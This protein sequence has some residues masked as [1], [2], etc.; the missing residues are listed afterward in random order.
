V[1][2]FQKNSITAVVII[3]AAVLLIKIFLPNMWDII[4]FKPPRIVSSQVT[5]LTADLQNARRQNRDWEDRYNNIVSSSTTDITRLN[6]QLEAQLRTDDSLRALVAAL[7]GR[8]TTVHT[9]EGVISIG[10]DDETVDADSS[11]SIADEFVRIDYDR[12]TSKINW[13]LNAK[14]E[15]EGIEKTDPYGNRRQIERVFLKSLISDNRYPILWTASYITLKDK[16]KLFH[17]WNPRV[18]SDLMFLGDD[19]EYGLS[20][21][22]A[23][24]GVKEYVE[25][26]YMYFASFG[27]ASNFKDKGYITFTPLKYNV[28][29]AL[30][31]ISNLN[32]SASL[33]WEL[34]MPITTGVRISLGFVH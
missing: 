5:T 17:W 7:E 28:G 27:V 10:N 29:K 22:L 20:V 3:I 33:I 15:L 16:I 6:K 31:L 19:I 12:I 30:P 25:E 18:Q 23:S 8:L 24:F 2:N 13:Q 32:V 26:T 1:T 4:R 34:N 21:N 9:G 11:W 14:I